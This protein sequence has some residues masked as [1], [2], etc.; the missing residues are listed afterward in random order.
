MD[1]VKKNKYINRSQRITSAPKLSKIFPNYY[2]PVTDH[3]YDE[4][5]ALCDQIE[6]TKRRNKTK[7]SSVYETLVS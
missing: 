7:C 2:A 5:E 6:K 3:N 4:F 1:S